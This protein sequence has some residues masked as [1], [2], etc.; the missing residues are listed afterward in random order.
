MTKRNT[1]IRHDFGWPPSWRDTA[2]I[3]I[4]PETAEEARVRAHTGLFAFGELHRLRRFHSP[5][6]TG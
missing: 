2:I 1:L 4:A 5:E 6:E 3:R